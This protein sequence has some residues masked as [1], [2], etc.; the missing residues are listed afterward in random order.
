MK[1][2]LKRTVLFLSVFIILLS[3]SVPIILNAGGSMLKKVEKLTED[4]QKELA[5]ARAK[6]LEAKKNLAEIE[7][8]VK[9]NHNMSDE[10]WV[11]WRAWSEINGEHILYYYQNHM[12]NK[13]LI[14]R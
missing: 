9:K 7:A 6:L 14:V 8:K 11:E 12:D 2:N 4:E 13:T 3:I 1:T 5:E 10:D